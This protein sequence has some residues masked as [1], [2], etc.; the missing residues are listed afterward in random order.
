ME[1]LFIRMMILTKGLLILAD[2]TVF[3]GQ[4]FGAKQTIRGEVVFNTSMTGY[5]EILTDPAYFGQIIMF[6]TPTIGSYGINRD[7]FET[8]T[9]FA[10]GMI[11]KE[12][13]DAPSN[14]RSEDTLESF[15]QSYQMTGISGIDTRQLMR[16]IQTHGTMNGMITQ[17]VSEDNI[18]QIVEQLK[19]YTIKNSVEQTS[20]AK[21][22]VVPGRGK[23]IVLIDLGMKHGILRELTKRDCHITVVPY[24]YSKEK[25]VRLKPDGVLL[26]SGP[27]NPLEVHETIKTIETLKGQFPMF[28][29]GLGHQIIAIAFGAT[30]KK[31]TTGYRGTS[32]PVMDLTTNQTVMTTQ[33]NSYIVTE[34]SLAKTNLQK[35]HINLHDQTIAGLKHKQ[36]P[37]FSVQ[38]YPE[39]SPGPE[40]SIHLFDH[41][42]QLIAKR[43]REG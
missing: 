33:N 37:I 3:H 10:K 11:V 28:G 43:K 2:G 4:L 38:F 32:Y 15:L 18:G 23:R 39:G 27:G 17:T 9:P 20:I 25:I 21:P 19:S 35:S 6:T 42:L 41:F 14:F 29:I 12:L 36:L 1:K 31:S 7:D 26:S 16:H 24:N 8:I 40:D 13:S 5:Q 34:Q 30:V 22:Y